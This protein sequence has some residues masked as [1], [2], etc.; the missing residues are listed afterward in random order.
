MVILCR[1]I[2]NYR[3]LKANNIIPVCTNNWFSYRRIDKL[4]LPHNEYNNILKGYKQNLYVLEN[5]IAGKTIYHKSRFEKIH[6]LN[7]KK[8]WA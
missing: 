1:Y 3:S 4:T 6:N 5:N 2:E 8:R 7:T